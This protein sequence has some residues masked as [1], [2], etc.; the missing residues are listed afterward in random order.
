MSNCSGWA[1]LRQKALCTDEDGINKR[2]WVAV[3]ISI[4]EQFFTLESTDLNPET[5]AYHE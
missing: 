4:L 3:L 2:E 1:C 5:K